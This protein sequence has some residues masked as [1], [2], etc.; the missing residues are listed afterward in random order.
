MK[1]SNGVIG[2][3]KINLSK[4][5]QQADNVCNLKENLEK[6][7][8]TI[9]ITTYNSE[10]TI[11]DV[12]NALLFQDYPLKLLEVIVVDGCST[13][14]TIDK[15]KEFLG[16]YRDK[17]YDFKLIIHDRNYGVSKARNDGIRLARGKY[18]LI[19]DSDVIL[20]PNAI[21]IM[22][23]FLE[24]NSKVGFCRPLLLHDSRDVISRWFY[25]INVGRIRKLISCADAALIRREALKKAGL[26]DEAM[27]PPFSVDEDLELGARIWK[28]GYQGVMLGNVIARHLKV[29]GDAHL[30]RMIGKRK[31]NN[32]KMT[33]VTYGRWLIGYFRKSHRVSWYKFLKSLPL[34]LKFNFVFSSLFLPFTAILLLG[35]LI[36]L[37]HYIN[38]LALVCVILAYLTTLRDF[39]SKPRHIYKSVFLALLACINRSVRTL[40]AL[41]AIVE[42]KLTRVGKS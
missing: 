2:S 40:A 9:V 8:I 4:M 39:M 13:D 20:P 38:V 10:V 17:F 22:V 23:S 31:A 36:P 24:S 35:L 25:E 29:A 19:L 21:S 16:R 5:C 41:C 11:E 14:R 15:V 42:L 28:A 26:Y 12:L 3:S 27:G 18:I 32:Y 30:N 33:L 34:K 1:I 6:P 37:P 7:P